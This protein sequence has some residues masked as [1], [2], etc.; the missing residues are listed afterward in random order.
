MLTGLDDVVIR[1][2]VLSEAVI[3]DAVSPLLC[4]GEVLPLLI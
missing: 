3:V 2:A 1:Y 4:Q